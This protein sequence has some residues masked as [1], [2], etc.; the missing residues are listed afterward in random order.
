MRAISVL[1]VEDEVVVAMDIENALKE[2]GY[3]VVGHAQSSM[4][5]LEIFVAKSPDIVLLDIKLGDSDNGISIAEK[6]LLQKT[7]PFGIIYI[8]A[9]GDDANIDRAMKTMPLAYILDPISKQ[10]HHLLQTL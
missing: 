8:T 9:F 7:D 4:E 1:I 6:F 2:L 3:D 10:A 5:A